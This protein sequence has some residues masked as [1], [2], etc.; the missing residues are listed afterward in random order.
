MKK[1]K[2]I[3]MS[4]SIS[5]IISKT[6]NLNIP[7]LFFSTILMF[8]FFNEIKAQNVTCTNCGNN[9]ASYTD[10]M[11]NAFSKFSSF[12][13]AQQIITNLGS[14]PFVGDLNLNYFTFGAQ[15]NQGYV[16][17]NNNENDVFNHSNIHTMGQSSI[18]I[19]LSIGNLAK[20][21][22]N[23]SKLTGLDLYY[24]KGIGTY[25]LNKIKNIDKSTS[26]SN[27]NFYGIRYQL[28]DAIG[29]K[30][31][32]KWQGLNM[33]FAYADSSVTTDNTDLDSSENERSLKTAWIAN[34]SYNIKSVT[35]SILLEFDTA[36][37]LIYFLNLNIGLGLAYSSGSSTLMYSRSSIN[38]SCACESIATIL[39]DNK[40]DQKQTL[41]L[42]TGIEF[43]FPFYHIGVEMT[44]FVIDNFIAKSNITNSYAIN[45][46]IDF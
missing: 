31:L 33:L 30:L 40:F 20:L 8:S 37:R 25:G 46:R 3:I 21:S 1:I 41:F 4:N 10:V 22:G 15:Y 23:N 38:E 32:A 29:A 44:S 26:T 36:A 42:K 2:M 7:L 39:Q 12:T 9:E 18:F 14:V 34:N 6:I 43:S 35:R 45:S 28:V 27:S 16:N 19:G 11:N 24:G 5:L 17:I 13:P